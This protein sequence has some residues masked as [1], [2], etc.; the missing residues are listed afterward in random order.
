MTNKWEGDGG[1]V[2]DPEF[3]FVEK[4][5]GLP[6]WEATIAV[7]GTRYDS[8]AGQQTV[9]TTWVR[10]KAYG[11]KAEE[12]FEAG[13]AKGDHLLIEGDLAQR[14]IETGD[15]KDDKTHINVWRAT[16][17]RRRSTAPSAPAQRD[18]R[19]A[20][21]AGGGSNDPWASAPPADEPPF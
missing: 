21:A 9:T 18:Q 3:A 8:R 20:A 19:P 4:L 7:N 13:Y 5:G 16:A 2:R 1:L 6:V 12:L 17:L 14:I 10:L 11:S 15:R